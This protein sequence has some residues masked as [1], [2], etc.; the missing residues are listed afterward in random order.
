[1][2][3]GAEGNICRCL[4]PAAHREIGDGVEVRLQHFGVL[5]E[6]VSEGVKSVQRDEQVSGCHPFLET[7]KKTGGTEKDQQGERD[8]RK[9][10][11][12]SI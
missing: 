10:C 2:T 9:H 12:R 1:M 3:L 6:L 4:L 11:L 8:V 5:E 7:T